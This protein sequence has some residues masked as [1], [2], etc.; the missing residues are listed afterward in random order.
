MQSRCGN[1]DRDAGTMTVTESPCLHDPINRFPGTMGNGSS[2]AGSQGPEG[3]E[4]PLRSTP[5]SSG[6]RIHRNRNVLSDQLG[7]PSGPH[8]FLARPEGQHCYSTL[9]AKP[10]SLAEQ[11]LLLKCM[12]PLYQ[13]I[14]SK[15]LLGIVSGDEC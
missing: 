3:Y 9:Q 15:T 11:N 8:I 12:G 1:K 2:E 6:L 14:T 7:L 13:F 5:V 10:P 4:S